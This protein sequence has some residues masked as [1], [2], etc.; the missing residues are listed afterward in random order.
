MFGITLHSPSPAKSRNKQKIHSSSWQTYEQKE[1]V[2]CIGFQLTHGG[3]W[4]Y[5]TAF[6]NNCFVTEKGD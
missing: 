5:I 6:K 1:R 2:Y 3:C 4:H